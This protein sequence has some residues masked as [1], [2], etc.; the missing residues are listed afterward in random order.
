MTLI[1]KTNN[2]IINYKVKSEITLYRIKSLLVV[3]NKLS[4]IL[5][6]YYRQ[7]HF[8]WHECFLLFKRFLKLIVEYL[9]QLVIKINKLTSLK[10]IKFIVRRNAISDR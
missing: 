7:K 2:D 3:K 10:N 8:I 4:S 9:E 5:Y 6:K 1:V